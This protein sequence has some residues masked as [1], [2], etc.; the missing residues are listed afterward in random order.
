M[1]PDVGA[2][3]SWDDV[4]GTTVMVQLR[5]WRG[6]TIVHRY[7]YAGTVV[8]VDGDAVTVET[9]EGLTAMPAALGG[10][11]PV[12]PGEYELPATGEVV[13]DPDWFVPFRIDLTDDQEPKVTFVPA[14]WGRS[15]H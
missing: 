13:V 14:S 9:S 4:I 6:D 10:F 5:F 12:D 1:E 11:H 3:V 7:Q 15:R 2:P 8:G